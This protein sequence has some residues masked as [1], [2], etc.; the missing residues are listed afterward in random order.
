MFE[1]TQQ[2]KQ[3]QENAQI[4][5]EA[6]LADYE[7]KINQYVNG[8]REQITVDKQEYEQLKADV[9][10]L[11][12]MNTGYQSEIG[13]IQITNISPNTLKTFTN[14]EP[15]LYFV[16]YT[17]SMT[18]GKTG[19]SSIFLND[20]VI[21]NDCAPFNSW[22]SPAACASGIVNITSKDDIIKLCYHCDGVSSAADKR[23]SWQ[24]LRL[25]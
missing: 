5:E 7:N 20:I 8:T 12:N 9:Q 15:G 13:T 23:Y 16:S 17:Q 22:G 14:L 10:A 18:V 25:K 24:L 3:E 4:K 2:A 6:T 1:K 21:I 11:K 19:Y